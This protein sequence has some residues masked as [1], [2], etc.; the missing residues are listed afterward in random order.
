MSTDAEREA[1]FKLVEKAVQDL[2]E[3]FDSVQIYAT[4]QTEKGALKFSWGAGNWF[5]R[6]GQVK[7]W[8]VREE[9]R[10]RMEVHE[11]NE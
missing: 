8:I 9:E 6:Y 11:D 4:S 3:H 1:Q 10:S 2:C 7:E 5:T